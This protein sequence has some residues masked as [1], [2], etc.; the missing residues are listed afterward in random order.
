MSVTNPLILFPN[1]VVFTYPEKMWK[2]V[3]LRHKIK[4]LLLMRCTK[5]TCQAHKCHKCVKTDELE[6]VYS[7]SIRVD[8]L[9][10]QSNIWV[11]TTDKHLCPL[12]QQHSLSVCP[13]ARLCLRSFC[14]PA[15]PYSSIPHP[16]SF[17][18]SNLLPSLWLINISATLILPLS[19][20]QRK[21]RLH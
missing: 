3:L 17:L 19:H 7:V 2:I 1:H 15:S 4:H 6:R 11:W 14:A 16:S 18:P 13:W 9:E 8:I 12:R 20:S 5:V 21:H 10:Q